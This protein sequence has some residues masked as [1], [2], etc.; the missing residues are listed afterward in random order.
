[1]HC[2]TLLTIETNELTTFYLFH[3]LPLDSC[4]FLIINTCT[5]RSAEKL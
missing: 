2:A 5:S 1:M 3:L 4:M